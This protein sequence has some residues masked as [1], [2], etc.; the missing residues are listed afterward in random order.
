LSKKKYGVRIKIV[1]KSKVLNT[2]NINIIAMNKP[3]S[4]NLF[5]KT[6]FNA[7]LLA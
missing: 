4:P 6:A 7:A 1:P 3:K 2:I 5:I